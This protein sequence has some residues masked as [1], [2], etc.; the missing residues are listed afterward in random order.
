MFTSDTQYLLGWQ[1]LPCIALLIPMAN[2]PSRPSHS[3]LDVLE[4]RPR[5]G[6]LHP[7]DLQC[8]LVLSSVPGK[9]ANPLGRPVLGQRGSLGYVMLAARCHAAVPEGHCRGLLHRE[10]MD[11]AQVLWKNMDS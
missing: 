7:K 11:R 9:R 3:Y 1:L 10:V 2:P 6:N 8:C 4:H 5:A